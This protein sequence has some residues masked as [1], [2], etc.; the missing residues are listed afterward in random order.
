MCSM[1]QYLWKNTTWSPAER[2]QWPRWPE[3]GRASADGEAAGHLRALQPVQSSIRCPESPALSYFGLEN[4]WIYVYM[5]LILAQSML[6]TVSEPWTKLKVWKLQ[7]LTVLALLSDIMRTHGW[8]K[9]SFLF[10]LNYKMILKYRKAS[11]YQQLCP[12]VIEINMKTGI[13]T[14][15]ATGF[16]IVLQLL[17]QELWLNVVFW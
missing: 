2:R 3:G 9:L 5:S 7:H 8:L 15:P 11:V 4:T 14:V 1:R 10:L 6:G 16:I 17:L 13:S 12:F